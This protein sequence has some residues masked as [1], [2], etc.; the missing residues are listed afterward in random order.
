MHLVSAQIVHNSYSNTHCM[1]TQPVHWHNE[2]YT[3]S[4]NRCCLFFERLLYQL[5]IGLLVPK[6]ENKKKDEE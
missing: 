6:S 3:P 5:R 4:M 1:K 2:I